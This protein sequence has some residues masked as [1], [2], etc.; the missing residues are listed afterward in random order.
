MGTKKAR[1]G[2]CRVCRCSII[3]HGARWYH[4]PERPTA[5][6][7]GHFAEPLVAHNTAPR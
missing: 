4:T 1:Y 3:N 5:P 2:T 6:Y 7:A